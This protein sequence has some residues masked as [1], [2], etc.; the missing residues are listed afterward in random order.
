MPMDKV[1]NI[2]VGDLQ[3]I[4]VYAERD[5]QIYQDIPGEVWDAYEQ[6]VGAGYT[7]QLVK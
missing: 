5:F 4:K 1:I 3:R 7:E 6:L 2:M